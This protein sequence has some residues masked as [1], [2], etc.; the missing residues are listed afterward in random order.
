MDTYYVF[1]RKAGFAKEQYG[2]AEMQNICKCCYP[3]YG[4]LLA[5]AP[6]PAF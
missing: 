2:E 1:L 4:Q 5:I 3:R 6:S